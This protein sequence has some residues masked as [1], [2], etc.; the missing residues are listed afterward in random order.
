MKRPDSTQW[1]DSI[2]CEYDSLMKHEIWRLVP[3][4]VNVNIIASKWVFKTKVAKNDADLEITKYKSRL[5][6]KGYSQIHGVD[7]EETFA[8]VVKFR[9]I[10]ILLA[11]VT[12]FNLE[13]HLMDVVTA[14][15]NGDLDEIIHMEQPAGFVKA[16]DTDKVCRLRKRFMD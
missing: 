15:L 2:Q 16:E 9:S 1:R 5:I 7:Y 10:R 3:R 12:H 14:F 13:L 8:P 11:F 6:A 4:H